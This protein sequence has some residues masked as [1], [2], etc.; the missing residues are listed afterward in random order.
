MS[1]FDSIKSFDIKIKLIY[2]KKEKLE[3]MWERYASSEEIDH[4]QQDS[5]H[6]SISDVSYWP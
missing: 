6:D 3:N 2:C 5:G 1:V 4:A